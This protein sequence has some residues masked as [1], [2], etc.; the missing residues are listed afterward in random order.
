M[1]QLERAKWSSPEGQ[2]GLS[3]EN[4]EPKTIVPI[5]NAGDYYRGADGNIRPEIVE[6][7]RQI[8]QGKY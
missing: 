1:G 3:T 5:P 7:A 4:P 8:S 6:K 2:Q